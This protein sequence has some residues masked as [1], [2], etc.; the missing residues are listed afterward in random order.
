MDANHH[1]LRNNTTSSISAHEMIH[2]P[3]VARSLMNWGLMAE[4]ATE[5]GK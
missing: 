3:P 1:D 5:M 2:R 4:I